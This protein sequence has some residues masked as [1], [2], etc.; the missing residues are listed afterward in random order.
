MS[1]EEGDASLALLKDDTIIE[2]AKK[3]LLG[4][5]RDPLVLGYFL[6]FVTFNWRFFYLLV[7]HDKDATAVAGIELAA[8]QLTWRSYVVPVIVATVYAVVL[9]FVTGLAFRIREYAA[10]ELEGWRTVEGAKARIKW[11][12]EKRKA[13]EQRGS[14]HRRVEKY[15]RLYLAR[16]PV[17]STQRAVRS[18][19]SAYRSI[20]Q[21]LT[22]HV[23][24]GV[25]EGACRDGDDTT[26]SLP[27]TWLRAS[28]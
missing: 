21:E 4:R 22:S 14:N 17:P 13:E 26:P 19:R 9:P 18:R 25:A 12:K 20:C 6:G 16:G 28:E 1:E 7:V 3:A 27:A 10:L 2:E 8:N 5:L 15:R 11:E 24:A 23:V